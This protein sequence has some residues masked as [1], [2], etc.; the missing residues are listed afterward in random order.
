[1]KRSQPYADNCFFERGLFA[2]QCYLF[3][4]SFFFLFGGGAGR[5]NPLLSGRFYVVSSELRDAVSQEI[6]GLG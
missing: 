6:S 4:Y 1:M 3:I 2:V 5:L